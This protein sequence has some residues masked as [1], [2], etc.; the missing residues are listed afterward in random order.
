MVSMKC[1]FCQII[2]KKKVAD[3]FYENE[4]SLVILDTDWAV[5]GHSLVIW[6]PHK[7][8]ASDLSEKEYGKFSKVA[9]QAEAALLKVLSKERSI[10]L[11]SGLL[12]SHFHFHIYPVD[13]ELS[14]KEMQEMVGKKH[15]VNFT[16]TEKKGLLSDLR[17]AMDFGV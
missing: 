4:D 5:K 9:R 10:I 13:M 16:E 3:V 14:F 1:A 2:D 7:L 17:R 6:K 8:N 15:R 12:V 11:K